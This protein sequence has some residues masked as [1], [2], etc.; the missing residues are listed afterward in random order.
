[1][2]PHSE[3][4]IQDCLVTPTCIVVKIS[5]V[6]VAGQCWGVD[7]SDVSD[8]ATRLNFLHILRVCRFDPQFTGFG[9]FRGHLNTFVSAI[10][11]FD[12]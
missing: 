12:Q 5:G 3:V 8:R 2:T 9:S 4:V 6:G 7:I 10:V 11:N 1:M